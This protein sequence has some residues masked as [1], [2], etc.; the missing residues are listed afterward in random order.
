MATNQTIET[1]KDMIPTLAVEVLAAKHDL[2]AMSYPDM[3]HNLHNIVT[4]LLDAA[5][6]MRYGSK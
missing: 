3:I 5:D 1:V 6:D 2:S 4:D